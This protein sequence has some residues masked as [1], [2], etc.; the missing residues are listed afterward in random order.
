MTFTFTT[1]Y[2]FWGTIILLVSTAIYY[3][4]FFSLVYY[5]RET[6]ANYVVVP[7][8]YTFDFFIAAFLIISFACIFLQYFPEALTLIR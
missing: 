3:I 5:W 2:F 1:S 7:L 6:R 4:I 8:L